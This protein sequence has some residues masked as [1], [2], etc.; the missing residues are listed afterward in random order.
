M[1]VQQPIGQVPEHAGDQQR[2]RKIAPGITGPPERL[3][4]ICRRV[5]EPSEQ[6][7]QRERQCYARYSDERY[8]VVLER[9]E[10]RASVRDIHQTEEVL[11]DDWWR[12]IRVYVAQDQI[13]R[14]PIEQIE[15]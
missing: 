4:T 10:R 11:N 15:R 8:V 7:N 1:S 5:V 12:S 3:G 6:K 9:T 13:F 14:P 2:K